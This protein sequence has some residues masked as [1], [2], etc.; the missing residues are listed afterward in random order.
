MAVTTALKIGQQVIK[1]APKLQKLTKLTK[2]Q[3]V[4]KNV[5]SSK[6]VIQSKLK[7]KQNLP[8]IA[9]KIGDIRNNVQQSSAI[10]NLN[11]SISKTVKTNMNLLKNRRALTTTIGKNIT[12]A[13][14]LKALNSS[15]RNYIGDNPKA[16]LRNLA[17][18]K[19]LGGKLF[20]GARFIGPVFEVM[21]LSEATGQMLQ[22]DYKKP[23]ESGPFNSLRNNISNIITDVKNI[24]NRNK[25]RRTDL[26]GAADI[27]TSIPFTG[28]KWNPFD[29]DPVLVPNLAKRHNTRAEELRKLD[30]KY[31][32]PKD[33]KK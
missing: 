33:K 21:R 7:L 6:N 3:K 23:I 29:D 15:L 30:T 16:L 28:Q 32:N 19:G 31:G 12:K 22:K 9:E 10:H 5:K 24:R 8:K 4:I 27:K 13:E 2:L 17:Q 26:Y 11:S 20:A 18:S 1:H 25:F 14:N